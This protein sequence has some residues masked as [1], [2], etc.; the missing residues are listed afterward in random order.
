M[1][2]LIYK[3]DTYYISDDI[4]DSKGKSRIL[5]YK[6]TRE[7]MPHKHFSKYIIVYGRHTCPYCIKTVEL[8]KKYP[9]VLFVEIDVEPTELFGK[10]NLLEI[11]KTE[12]SGHSTVPIVFD[13]G[14][15]VGGAS[16]AEKHFYK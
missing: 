14:A 12:I 5:K 3:N 4:S 1:K 11:L 10:Q 6:A 9:K 8:L 2:N 13:K 15:F 16:D 7:E